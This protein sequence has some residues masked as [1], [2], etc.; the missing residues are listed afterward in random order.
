MGENKLKE[1]KDKVVGSVKETTGKITDN[2]ELELKGK[3]QKAKGEAREFA[4]DVAD[5][6]DDVKDNV[7]GSVNRKIDETEDA[8]DRKKRER[9]LE[10]NRTDY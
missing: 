10:K 9:E 3:M 1:M 4:G 5:K 6:A 7:L 8:M 2:E